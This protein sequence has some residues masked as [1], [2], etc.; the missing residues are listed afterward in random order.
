LII[1]LS[2]LKKQGDGIF[3]KLTTE[4]VALAAWSTK[5]LTQAKSVHQFCGDSVESIMKVALARRT[6]DNITVVMIGFDHLKQCIFGRKKKQA[7]KSGHTS[8]NTITSTSNTA[9]TNNNNSSS[10]GN[11]N[12]NGNTNKSLSPVP[13]PSTAHQ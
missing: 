6:F 8:K 13:S 11:G 5:Y 4:D 3:D 7:S 1:I 2:F 10:N 12:G 9:T